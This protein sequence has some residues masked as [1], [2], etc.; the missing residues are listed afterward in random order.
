MNCKKC[1][2]PKGLV[3][4]CPNDC[5]VGN[6]ILWLT[7]A[8]VL[9]AGILWASTANANHPIVGMRGVMC[10]SKELMREYAELAI[11][12]PDV[13]FR[14]HVKA[15]SD[16]AGNETAC[17][18]MGENGRVPTTIVGP[19]ETFEFKGEN[20]LILHVMLWVSKTQYIDQFMYT[21]A[22]ENKETK[23]SEGIQA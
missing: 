16:N 18:V 10:D 22:G 21:V 15:V 23:E 14:L 2:K 13:D 4:T 17:M 3:H 9:G 5:Y 8:L 11:S 19:A 6:W 20:V 7:V 1:G 12:K